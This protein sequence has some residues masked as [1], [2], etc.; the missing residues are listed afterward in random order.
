MDRVASFH[1]VMSRGECTWVGINLLCL[2]EARHPNHTGIM[3]HPPFIDMLDAFVYLYTHGLTI[4]AI[5]RLHLVSAKLHRKLSP[6]LDSCLP[7]LPHYDLYYINLI[8][9]KNKTRLCDRPKHASGGGGIGRMKGIISPR[10]SSIRA[11]RML[12]HQWQFET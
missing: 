11:C 6:F 3:L 9:H 4:N 2:S 8:V 7:R 1:W 10:Q 12:A 5:T